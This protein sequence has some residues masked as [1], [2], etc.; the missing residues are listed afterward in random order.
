M[1]KK[2]AL[3]E[4]KYLNSLN[5]GLGFIY[6]LMK[7]EEDPDYWTKVREIAFGKESEVNGL[8]KTA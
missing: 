1:N 3:R 6:F 7:K 5:P 4:L 2:E 8:E